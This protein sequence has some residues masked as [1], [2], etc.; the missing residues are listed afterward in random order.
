[1]QFH[2]HK[3]WVVNFIEDGLTKAVCR[4]KCFASADKIRAMAERAG[5]LKTLE[6][7]RA[8]DYGIENGRGGL[9]L[10]LNRD[11]YQKLKGQSR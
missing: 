4:P 2:L 9:Y 7:Q 3:G 8:L 6:D 11:Q 10:V 1:M 5:A